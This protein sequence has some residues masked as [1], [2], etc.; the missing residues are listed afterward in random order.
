MICGIGQQGFMHGSVA[1]TERRCLI[2]KKSI[3]KAMLSF[4]NITPYHT[5]SHIV[6]IMK[7]AVQ[8][9]E[10]EVRLHSLCS[11]DHAPMGCHLFRS[12]EN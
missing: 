12:L 4:S 2:E 6:N 3:D 8:Q 7:R 10:N 5:T 9:L 1:P 11:P